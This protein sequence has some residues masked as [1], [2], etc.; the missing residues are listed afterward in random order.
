MSQP[1]G[2]YPDPTDPNQQRL[3]DGQRWSQQTRPGVSP[4]VAQLVAT[5]R[6]PHA[7]YVI[8]ALVAGAGIIIG[9]LGPWMTFMGMSRTAMDGDGAITLVLGVVAIILLFVVLVRNGVAGTVLCALAA[10]LGV[11]CVVT[12]VVDINDVTSR[13]AELFGRDLGA[14]VGWGLWLMALGAVVMSVAAAIAG[15]QIRTQRRLL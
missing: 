10:V 2:W 5:K 13:S 15:W 3:W 8:A 12:A 4:P 6:A 14:Q 11:V 1:N 9:S 7:P